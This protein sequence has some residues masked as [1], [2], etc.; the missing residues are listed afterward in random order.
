[1]CLGRG[2]QAIPFA[3]LTGSA[4]WS[5]N[6]PAN[7]NDRA[8]DPGAEDAFQDAIL[9][10]LVELDRLHRPASFRSGWQESH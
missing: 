3:A 7:G 2:A 10:A 8:T 4:P 5:D 1:M 6:V 9:L